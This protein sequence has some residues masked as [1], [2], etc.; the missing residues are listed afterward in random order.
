MYSLIQFYVQTRFHLAPYSPFIKVLAIKL[1]VFLSFW[2]SFM[3]SILTS[4]TLQI[5]KASPKLGWPDI[6]VGIPSLLLCI[7]MAIFAILHIF[8]FPYKPYTSKAEP[9]KYPVSGQDHIDHGFNAV[10]PKKGGPVGI[11]AII[12]ALNPWDLV[13]AFGRGIRWA[14]IGRRHR[15]TDMSYKVSSND[16]TLEPTTTGDNS[17]RS[18]VHLP[19]SEEFRRSKFGM[20]KNLDENAGLIEHAQ[21]QPQSKWGKYMPAKERYDP[22]TGEEIRAVG[23]LHS[24]GSDYT[25]D[26]HPGQP[27]GVGSVQIPF[28][29]ED[30]VAC[31]EAQVIPGVVKSHQSHSI[32]ALRQPEQNATHQ[33]LKGQ[34][35]SPENRSPPPPAQGDSGVPF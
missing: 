34:G 22:K 12:D 33:I 30:S 29:E 35:F 16:L 17:Y 27:V 6:L 20:P 19:I 8:A 7:E 2:Q 5:L 23:V 32:Q 11:Y 26:P 13:K 24:A 15:E 9:F 18:Q 1:V 14:F 21:P 28:N 31:Y 25:Y 4:P 3:I 10:G